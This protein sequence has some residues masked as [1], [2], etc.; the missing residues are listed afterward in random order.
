MKNIDN[1]VSQFTPRTQTTYKC[2]LNKFFKIIN[3]KP[4][5]YFNGKRHKTEKELDFYEK[6]IKKYYKHIKQMPPNTVFSYLGCIR[7]YLQDNYVDL[8]NAFWRQF[9]K[10]KKGNRAVVQDIVPSKKQFKKLLTH[11]SA[12]ERALI[13]TLLSSGMRIGEVCQIKEN[14]IDFKY[15]PTKIEIS[16]EYTKTGN[17]RTTFVTDECS[18]AIKEWLKEKPKWL[19]QSVKKLN[20]N[21][22]TK[23]TSDDRVFPMH[24]QTAR[25]KWNRLLEKA[26]E[27]F[28]Q[29]DKSTAKDRYKIHPHVTRKY[30]RT[31]MAKDIGRDLTEYFLGH[32]QGLDAVYRRYGDD[33][34][35]RILG[36]EYLKGVKN[37]S[38]FEKEPDL[39]EVNKEIADLRKEN[40]ILK[41]QIAE[42]DRLLRPKLYKKLYEENSG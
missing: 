34:N 11:G 5:T 8:P 27:E 24:T 15:K 16:G 28:N 6:D 19:E 20:F 17:K 4:E 40:E 13:L 25:V 12:L 30:Y 41:E 14:D 35:K 31:W 10:R 1:F 29:K 33:S 36:D 3:K 9:R 38:V 26:K 32:E 21:R 37:V 39:T 22:Y 23:N 42:I 18:E 7:V 2:V